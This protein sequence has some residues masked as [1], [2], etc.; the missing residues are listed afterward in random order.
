MTFIETFAIYFAIYRGKP[1]D[2][3]VET[4]NALFKIK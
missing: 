1:A 4:P 2:C 3:N